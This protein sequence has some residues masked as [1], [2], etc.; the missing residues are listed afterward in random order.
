M[1]VV[2]S[3]AAQVLQ[4]FQDLL[5]NLVELIHL[6]QKTIHTSDLVIDK[7]HIPKFVMSN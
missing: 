4:E 6:V 7:I 1:D 3:D 2:G 5:V